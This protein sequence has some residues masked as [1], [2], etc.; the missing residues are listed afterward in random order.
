VTP[1]SAL[2]RDVRGMIVIVAIPMAAILV[3]CLLQLAHVGAEVLQREQLQAAA[4]A[5]AWHSALL[6]ARGMNG[7]AMLNIVMA[8][9]LAVSTLVRAVEMLA[10]VGMVFYGTGDPLLRAASQTDARLG[11]RIVSSVAMVSKL[12]AGL[13]AAT[14]LLAAVTKERERNAPAALAFSY[15]LV[16]SARDAELEVD[17]ARPWLLRA[18]SAPQPAPR[19]AARLDQGAE[20]PSLALERDD[21]APLCAQAS[22]SGGQNLRALVSDVTRDRRLGELARQL[23]DRLTTPLAEHVIEALCEP[24]RA[25]PSLCAV[26]LARPAGTAANGCSEALAQ[27]PPGSWAGA[28]ALAPARV[29]SAAENGNVMLQ[30]WAIAQRAAARPTLGD[31]PAL[32]Q[33]EYYFACPADQPQWSQCADDAAWSL[34]WTAR[35]RRL[36]RPDGETRPSYA[37]SRAFL[38]SAGPLRRGLNELSVRPLRDP[39]RYLSAFFA[40]R[41]DAASDFIH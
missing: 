21:F 5:A 24:P 1:R 32:A 17:P 20:L 34:G 23:A 3:A 13:A 15:A 4:D 11:D 36:W 8:L 39:E 6:Y 41:R 18:R 40:T 14:P 35:L 25:Q 26:R 9:L 28:P 10:V 22:R 33:A 30:T 29:W 12:Q 38:S 37:I 19:L 27:L 16:P 2:P 7:A 31:E